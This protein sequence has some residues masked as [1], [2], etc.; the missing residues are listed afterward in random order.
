M[1]T[2]FLTGGSGFIGQYLQHSINDNYNIIELQNDLRDYDKVTAEIAAATPDIVL[3]LAARTEVEQSFY[4]QTEFSE[5]NYVGTVNLIEACAKLENKP[6]FI[7]A[8]TMEVYGKQPI[9]DSILNGEDFIPA[10]FDENT[11]PEPNAPYAVAK[12][13]CEKYLEYAGRSYGLPWTALRQTNTYGRKDND[14]FVIE[15]I[16]TQML[17]GD[18]CELG[19]GGPYR[20]FL[21]IDDLIAAWRALLDNQDACNGKIFTVGPDE[22]QQIEDIANRISEIMDWNGTI[23]WNTRPH[24]P[25]EIYWLNSSHDLLTSATGWE[26]LVSFEEG[27]KRTIEMWQT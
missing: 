7:F 2:I 18:T 5:I 12:Y 17:T 4:E 23:E 8:S 24:R 6:Y 1:K 3:H 15:R 10:V 13:A 16:I 26:P 27:I 21:Y 20:N 14:F 9:S 22:P 11:Q 25:G 19:Y